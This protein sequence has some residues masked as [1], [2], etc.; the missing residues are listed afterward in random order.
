MNKFTDKE[1][2]KHGFAAK[3]ISKKAKAG[4]TLPN[5]VTGTEYLRLPKDIQARYTLDINIFD[6]FD[7]NVWKLIKEE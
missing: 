4:F 1:L 6:A 5:D 2:R 7:L 3:G